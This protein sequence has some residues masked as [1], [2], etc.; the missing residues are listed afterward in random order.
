M[1]TEQDILAAAQALRDGELVAFPTETVYGLGANAL[2]PIAVAKIFE[3]KERPRFDPL[4]VHVADVSQAD[5]VVES[6]PEIAQSLM[7][8]FWPGPLSFVLNKLPCVPDIVTAGLP[9]VAIRCPSHDVARGLIRA[10]G[11]PIAAPSANRFGLVSP[12]TG[13]HVMES[14]GDR[15]SFVLD[16]GPCK[17]GVESTVVSFM[18]TNDGL[19]KLLRHGGITQE[20]IESVTGAINTQMHEE[21]Q[22]TSPGQLSRHYSPATPLLFSNDDSLAEMKNGKSKIGLLGF[23]SPSSSEDFAAIEI[24]SKKGDYREAAA[25]LF[26]AMRRLDALGLDLIIAEPIPEIDLGRAIMDRLRRAAAR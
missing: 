25:N 12:T 10:A 14:F 23:Q 7:E 13:S 17:I 16:D 5:E 3:I 9:G 1:L 8:K 6:I 11:V 2:N 15:L 19:P 4:I 21:S 26:A 18:D 22:P 24:L 20:Q